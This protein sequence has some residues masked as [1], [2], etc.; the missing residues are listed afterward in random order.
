MRR[1]A[2]GF[3]RDEDGAILVI[4]AVSLGMIL[5]MIALSYDL[6]RMAATQSELQSYADHVALAAAGELDGVVAQAASGTN[7]AVPGARERAQAAAANFFTDSQTFAN[8][9]TGQAL[10]SAD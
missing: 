5:G 1:T 8:D 3:A 6:G 2:A 9:V 7:P 4:V 10:D